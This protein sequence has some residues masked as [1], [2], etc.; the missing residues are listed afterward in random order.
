MSDL[1]GEGHYISTELKEYLAKVKIKP[2]YGRDG[3]QQTSGK[4]ERYHRSMKN[5][6]KLDNYYHPQQLI[7]AIREFVLYYNYKCYHE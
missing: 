5:V 4:I 2:I 7:V 3:H 6:V 1:L